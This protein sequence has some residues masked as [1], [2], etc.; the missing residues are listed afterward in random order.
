[1]QWEQC[2][3]LDRL[4]QRG[5]AI[6]IPRKNWQVSRVRESLERLIAD[7]A[8]AVAARELQEEL[9]STDGY[10]M[11][12]DLIWDLLSEISRGDEPDM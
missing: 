12:G 8:H 3:S 6:R 2:S 4:V 1:M 5:S 9:A 11:T 7:P 10:Q